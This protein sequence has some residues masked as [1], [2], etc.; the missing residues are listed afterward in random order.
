MERL[1]HNYTKKLLV[2]CLKFKSNNS[3]EFFVCRVC[4][5]HM[6]ELNLSAFSPP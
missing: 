1:G 5:S 2:I 6:H 3:H 4:I